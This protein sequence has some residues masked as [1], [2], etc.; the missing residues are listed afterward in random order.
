VI[1][2]GGK[3]FFFSIRGDSAFGGDKD[4]KKGLANAIVN[5]RRK[6][7]LSLIMMTEVHAVYYRREGWLHRTVNVTFLKAVISGCP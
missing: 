5:K 2:S 6:E 3:G 1:A 4:K 7:A